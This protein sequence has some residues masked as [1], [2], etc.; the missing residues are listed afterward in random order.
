MSS[1]PWLTSLL[2]VCALPAIDRDSSLTIVYT[3]TAHYEPRA[4]VQGHDRFPKGASLQILS[5]GIKR[6]LVP[7][8]SA[9]A[10]AE[11]SYDASHVLFAGK[12]MA[13]ELWQV[14]ELALAGGSPRQITNE[15]VNC[16]RP[17]Y[18]P[19]GRIVFTAGPALEVVGLA[20]GVPAPLTFTPQPVLSDQVLQDGRILLEM[21]GPQRELFTVYPDGTGLESV[22]CDHGPDRGEARQLSSGDFVFTVGTHLARFAPDSAVQT[23]LDQPEGEIA[24]PIAEAGPGD[25]IYSARRRDGRF[26]LYRKGVEIAAPAVQ[27]AIVAPSVPPKRFPSA[28]VP[29]RSWGNLLCLDARISKEPLPAGEIAQVRAFTLDADRQPVLLGQASVERDGSFYLKLPADRPLR[30]EIAD[31]TGRGIRAEHGWFWMRP[32]EQRVC[33][34]CHAGPERSSE[35]K[36]PEVLLRSTVPYNMLGSK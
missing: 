33:V 20:G 18:L 27:P 25:W 2:L 5:A 8:F 1:K 9:S 21:A 24:G 29:T 7:G 31:S 26:A 12:R 28:L 16:V 30:L 15:K 4:W 36:V 19:D 17:S 22:R 6:A 35:N 23:G 32:A 11:V 14:W 3:Q 13:G 10:D 34:G